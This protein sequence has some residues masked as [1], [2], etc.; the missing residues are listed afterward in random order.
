MEI[1]EILESAVNQ[2]ASDLHL[3]VEIPP[4]FRINGELVPQ[5]NF[6]PLLPE[7]LEKI[8]ECIATPQ[9]RETFEKK[10]ELDLSYEI[11]GLGRFRISVVKQRSTLSFAFRL[12]PVNMLSFDELGLPKI[13]K[14]LVMKPRGLIL[15]TGASGS[16]KSTTLNAMVNFLNE[17]I[18]RN[19]I[20]IEDPIEFLHT[21]KKC[22]IAQQELGMDTMEFAT[23]LK[24]ALRHDPDVLVIGEIRDY[25]TM[26]TVIRAAKTG[27]LVLS[28]MH[29]NDAAQTID[30]T[31]NL[32]PPGEKEQV[33]WQLSSVIEAVICQT[34]IPRLDG[35]GRVVACEV[36]TGSPA[37]RNLIREGKSQEISGVIEF[38]ARESMQ[39]RDQALVDLVNKGVISRD[40]AVSECGNLEHFSSLLNR[41]GAFRYGLANMHG[42]KKPNEPVYGV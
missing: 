6:P 17:N 24:H 7:D 19:I 32:F 15:I 42:A 31:I 11:T 12:V 21:N 3:Q 30:A 36:M 13:C 16:G 38:S 4:V 18:R 2:K 28:T 37:V 35:K 33:R 34:L 23:A 9:Q 1:N 39:T 40:D 10:L 8:F 27:H 29:T 22:I 25:D 5:A 26:N 20:M 41:Q 14:D